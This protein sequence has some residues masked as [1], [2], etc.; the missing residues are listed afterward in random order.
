MPTLTVGQS[1]Q[2]T[3]LASYSDGST[4]DITAT[5]QWVNNIQSIASITS[6][7]VV[8][9]VGA[10]IEQLTVAGV[11]S[12][13]TLTVTCISPQLTGISVASSASVIRSESAFKYHALAQ[14]SDGTTK[15]VTSLAKW[16]VNDPVIATIQSDGTLLCNNPGSD[17]VMASYGGYFSE[18]S[19]TCVLRNITPKPGFINLGEQ[20]EGPFTSWINVKKNFGAK[21]DGVSD[22]TASIQLALDTISKNSG[23]LWIPAGTYI[24]S[25]TLNI[26]GRQAF[27]II[28]EDPLTTKIKWAG[29]SHGT[30]LTLSGC[31]RF[32]LGRLTID[33]SGI[34]DAA[35]NLTWDQSSDYYPTDNYI[36]DSIIRYAG[37][38]I[39][40]GW[41]GE[42][43]IERV[44]F[45]HNS[46]AGV[47]LG[48]WDA[49]N[50]NIIDSLF[51]D[52]AI[53]ITNIYGA[54]AFN[55]G[56]SVFARS[57]ISDIA[58]GNTGP[59]SFRSNL[60]VDSNSFI[61]TGDT[62]AP[63]NII[64]QDNT[65]VNSVT[66]PIQTGTPGSLLVI[67]NKFIGLSQ[68][69]HV[70]FSHC[71]TPLSFIAVGNTYAT[72][73]PFAGNIGTVIEA[74]EAPANDAPGLNVPIP[75]E[76]YFPNAS[77]RQTI[78]VTPGAGWE[79]VQHAVDLATSVHGV[80]HIPAG[81]YT[82]TRTISISSD[83]DIVIVGDG[84]GT[85]LVADQG[86]QGSMLH[87]DG[88]RLVLRDMSLSSSA[89]LTAYG[90]LEITQPDG[91]SSRILFDDCTTTESEVRVDGMDDT[92]IEFRVGAFGTTGMALSANG[93]AAM[94]K[95][96]KTFGHIA[97]LMSSISK[98]SVD[99]G[100]NLIVEDGWHDTGQGPTQFALSGVGSV[101]HEGGAIYSSS[102]SA[103]SLTG[104]TGQVALMGT[105]T[106]SQLAVD[107]TSKANVL[108]AGVIKVG[109]VNPVATADPTSLVTLASVI[110]GN[111]YV[112]PIPNAAISQADLVRLIA[113]ARLVTPLVRN[114]EVSIA[115]SVLMKRLDIH[116]APLGIVIHDSSPSTL[117]GKYTIASKV[118]S[119][120]CRGNGASMAGLWTIQ[121]GTDG[122]V[123]LLNGAQV[124]S[125][126]ADRAAV[127]FSSTMASAYDR[128]QF[129]DTGDG[130]LSITN[131][132]TGDALTG[133]ADGCVAVTPSHG[134]VSQQW[135]VA[136]GQ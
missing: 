134:D 101:T 17:V 104:F 83:A 78:E 95:G 11:P 123:G 35:L 31:M 114:A 32:D 132:A 54:G 111:N 22:D 85:R 113:T 98:Y 10:G 97:E 36:H 45:D 25:D 12:V 109:S 71:Y 126:R 110:S 56:N 46:Q 107:S 24:I 70:L 63:A 8:T 89:S 119:G 81:Q 18:A 108:A 129:V 55:V 9:C 65:I 62:G 15:D 66:T 4:V 43:T 96:I 44:H 34:T 59:F 84:A 48:D 39:E 93:G 75:T 27:S 74:D 30:M 90:L 72:S 73:T 120:V 68:T 58:I 79:D 115:P 26:S 37:K 94:Q 29:K 53:G 40:S 19:Y 121:T 47:S 135:I 116:N 20:F 124:L 28:G 5:A 16:S 105:I 23:V 13:N 131:R 82:I 136:T 86:I 51:T 67:D 14:F 117:H 88:G 122:F 100:A 49:L 99:G 112:T 6:F 42:T 80:V 41:A 127:M 50:W 69:S 33:G 106:N 91:P 52:N 64:V 130:S 77:N 92:R 118:G 21:G 76:V 1:A 87:S 133:L 2:I 7:G 103:M 61:Q 57:T 38:G 3:V 125:E 128:W 102:A 60:S